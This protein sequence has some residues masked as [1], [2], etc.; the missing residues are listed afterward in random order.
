MGYSD[1]GHAWRKDF[2]VPVSEGLQA[3]QAAQFE[4]HTNRL[5]LFPEE[6]HWIQI[7]TKWIALAERIFGV[8]G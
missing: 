7:P 3:Y 8:A 5:V 6:G 2:R 4:K 1:Q